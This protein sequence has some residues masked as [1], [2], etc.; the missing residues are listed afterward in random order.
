MSNLLRKKIDLASGLPPSV[1][2]LHAL[3]Q[4][5][6]DQVGQWARK[7]FDYD[8]SPAIAFRKVLSGTEAQA[9]VEDG[10]A[11]CFTSAAS[12]GLVAILLDTG[13]ATHAA[14]ARLR[15]VPASL[16]DSSNL[17]LRL[18][19]EQPAMSLW[20][21]LVDDLPGH[22]GEVEL[23]PLGEPASVTGG[24]EPGHRYLNTTVRMD[25]AEG[26]GRI[27][28]LFDMDYLQATAR[29]LGHAASHGGGHVSAQ[30]LST[31]RERVRGSTI[32]LDA[33]LDRMT[34]SLGDCSRLEVGQVLTLSE[35]NSDRLTLC[36]D[37]VNGSVDIGEGQLGVWKQRRAMKLTTEVLESFTRDLGNL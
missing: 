36:A 9:L 35:V 25:L 2:E 7:T 22:S 8:A 31:L 23:P 30:G 16:A 15:Q 26:E 13:A 14:A 11:S 27:S 32:T 28:F 34:M 24:F 29:G 37:T 6:V 21:D 19:S 1:L 12:P 4:L 5:M 3:W 17:F 10:F 20:Q 18:M 33:V